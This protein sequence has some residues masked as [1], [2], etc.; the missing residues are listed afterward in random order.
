MLKRLWVIM[1]ATLREGLQQPIC[2]LLTLTMLVLTLLQPLV[3]LHTFGEAG[4]LVRDGGFGFQLIFGLLIVVFTAGFTLSNELRSGTAAASLVKPVS[5]AEFFVGKLLGVLGVLVLYWICSTFAI[6]IAERAAERF[7]ENARIIGYVRDTGAAAL[8]LAVPL[9]A[10]IF[11]A[12]MNYFRHT[13]IGL[14]FFS[15]TVVLYVALFIYLC[16]YSYDRYWLGF[17][18]EFASFYDFRLLSVSFLLLLLLGCFTTMAVALTTR[19]K[20]GG[21][22][23]ICF[24][25]FSLGF[26]ID[27]MLESGSCGRVFGNALSLITPN[28]QSY[29]LPDALGNGGTISLKYCLSATVNSFLYILL[30]CFI[31]I[32]LLRTKDL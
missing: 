12:I 21:A 9:L 29:W 19:I 32:N 18:A 17:S 27:L 23:A 16:F 24:V 6:L 26:F 30:Y 5:R 20:T 25:L 2:M 13:R 7:V 11:A 8:G 10:L 28:V 14:V 1:Y 15:T 3:Q 22:L 4:R 31:G